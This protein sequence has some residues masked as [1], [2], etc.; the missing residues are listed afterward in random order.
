MSKN[1]TPS[2]PI[3][4]TPDPETVFFDR[5]SDELEQLF[6]KKKCKERSQALVLNAKANMIF[7]SLMPDLIELGRQKGLE[8]ACKALEK[9]DSAIEGKY[10]KRDAEL[11]QKGASA[12]H[13]TCSERLR[14]LRTTRRKVIKPKE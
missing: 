13:A 6:P 7:R 11:L 12:M 3:D 14:I 5:L 8:Q 2:K 9:V 10:E 4:I 1:H